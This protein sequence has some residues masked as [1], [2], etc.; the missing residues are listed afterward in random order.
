VTEEPEA[1]LERL[2]VGARRASP[3]AVVDVERERT[4]RER[5]SGQ[6]GRAVAITVTGEDRRCTL[7]HERGGWHGEIARVVGGIVIARERVPLGPWLDA[8]AAEVAA[9]AARSS[10]D[11]ASARRAYAVL[12]LEQ[13]PSAFT[14]DRDDAVR[15]L[16]GVLEEA[17]R[18]LPES[19]AATV[20][21]IVGLLQTALPRTTG[22]AGALVAR[23]ATVYL[24]DTLR[25][26]VALPEDWAR[27]G[28]LRDGSTAADALQAQLAALEDAA[29][30]MRDAAVADDADALLLNGMFLEQRFD[31]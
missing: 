17:R 19:A 13:A 25:A 29:T 21:R 4:L 24:P 1:F 16:D 9:S 18:R 8:F 5:L 14:V 11:A 15:G 10:G 30:R 26:Y 2:A 23:T 31:A 7:R 3:D 12:G 27:S 22:D 20:A 28:T 6:Q